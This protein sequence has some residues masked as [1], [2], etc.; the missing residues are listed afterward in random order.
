MSSF[1]LV[2]IFQPT[3][4]ILKCHNSLHMTVSN[5]E[6][7][8]KTILADASFFVLFHSASYNYSC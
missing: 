6:P 2:L 7:V 5:F 1:G 8:D 3:D 4:E